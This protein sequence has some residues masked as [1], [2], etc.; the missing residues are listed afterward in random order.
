MSVE[1]R[2]AAV[3]DLPAMMVLVRELAEYERL[4]HAMVAT[5]ES[6][7]AA[8]FGE[9]PTGVQMLG[10]ALGVVAV[11]LIAWPAGGKA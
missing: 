3:A 1:I 6:F 4:A 9:R 5:V 7:Q 11:A 2:P 8:L 10:M